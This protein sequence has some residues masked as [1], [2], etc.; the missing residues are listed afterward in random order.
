MK[1][2]SQDGQSSKLD[3]P[4]RTHDPVRTATP[5]TY[6]TSE[7][8]SSW[9]L[10]TAAVGDGPSEEVCADARCGPLPQS[11]VTQHCELSRRDVSP[12]G[13]QGGADCW[14]RFE[15]W[16][17]VESSLG[18][19]HPFRSITEETVQ[20]A[21]KEFTA[22]KERRHRRQRVNTVVDAGE[23]QN[24][25]QPCHSA[26]PCEDS[27]I[28]E[29]ACPYFQ[30]K[31]SQYANCL[32]YFR[33]QSVCDVREHVS[34]MHRIPFYCPICKADFS[35]AK[36]RDEH[37]VERSCV[38]QEHFPIEGVNDDQRKEIFRRRKRA[39]PE[40]QWLHIVKV[41]LPA[42]RAS[43]SPYIRT[44]PGLEVISLRKFWSIHGER[45][46][47]Q[48]VN[49]AGLQD[50]DRRSKER[51]LTS[52]YKEVLEESVEQILN[53]HNL[54]TVSHAACSQDGNGNADG[55]RDGE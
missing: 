38:T 46:I 11:T 4:E 36:I 35:T 42:V 2:E 41:L 51:D 23:G 31:P 1:L 53:K 54:R 27:A 29:F 26:A 14:E 20:R 21:G 12:V 18:D 39:G 13:K 45:I 55:H 5:I 9:L 28:R 16:T 22:W 52:F 37:I 40:E 33:L 50:W 43:M 49:A 7:H 48:S 6:T 24:G 19:D 15:D 17:N 3:T 44:E 10:G 47:F 30:W 32:K 8:V 34:Q 25:S